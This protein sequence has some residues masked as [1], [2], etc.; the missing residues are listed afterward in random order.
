MVKNDEGN[1]CKDNLLNNLHKDIEDMIN[2]IE[3]SLKKIQSIC[4]D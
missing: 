4:Y 2:K 1:R 3:S